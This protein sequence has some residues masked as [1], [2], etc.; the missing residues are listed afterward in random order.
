[1][2]AS[3]A[4]EGDPGRFGDDIVG[5]GEQERKLRGITAMTFQC[6]EAEAE[7]MNKVPQAVP[8]DLRE[9]ANRGTEIARLEALQQLAVWTVNHLRLVS[10]RAR[11]DPFDSE[12]LAIE[13]PRGPAHELPKYEERPSK[14]EGFGRGHQVGGV[15]LLQEQ[16]LQ[17]PGLD[18]EKVTSPRLLDQ[19]R[20]YVLQAK[21]AEDLRVAN[22]GVPRHQVRLS[23]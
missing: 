21:N 14:A 4:E 8:G 13:G 18:G 1:M 6:R 5:H 3:I 19:E 2:R 16:L 7:G 10:R 20:K 22:V 12:S 9:G 11:A 15:E 23:L 17:K